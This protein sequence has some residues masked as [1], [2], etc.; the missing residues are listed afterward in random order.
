M[1]RPTGKRASAKT[2]NA[3]KKRMAKARAAEIERHFVGALFYAK[4]SVIRFFEAYERLEAFVARFPFP[5]APEKE[6]DA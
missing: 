2:R 3:A 6:N 4:L 5:R 1:S